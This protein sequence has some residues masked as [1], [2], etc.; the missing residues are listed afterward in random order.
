MGPEGLG[1]T[2]I[3]NAMKDRNVEDQIKELV[4]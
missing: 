2:N 3:M 1:I 4:K